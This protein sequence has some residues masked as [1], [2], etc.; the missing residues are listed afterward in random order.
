MLGSK[1]LRSLAQRES[2]LRQE[3]ERIRG[4]MVNEIIDIMEA[5]G[6]ELAHLR[7][8]VRDRLE[9]RRPTRGR[10]AKRP[11]KYRDDMTGDTWAGVGAQ[12]KWIKDRLSQGRN[13]EDFYVG[14]EQS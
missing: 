5:H 11:T 2:K 6:I 7:E 1:R 9:A 4:K 8:V 12:P 14:P 13:L 10:N 3:R